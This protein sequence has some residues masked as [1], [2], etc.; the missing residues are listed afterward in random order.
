MEIV[1]LGKIYDIYAPTGRK[2]DTVKVT[3]LCGT[4]FYCHSVLFEYD[5]GYDLSDG[6]KVT[7]VSDGNS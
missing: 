4:A 5:T 3:E 2:L 1:E 6:I 7:E